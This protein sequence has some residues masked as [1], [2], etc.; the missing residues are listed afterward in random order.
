MFI[1]RDLFEEVRIEPVNETMN[2]RGIEADIES[3]SPR[4]SRDAAEV[5]KQ[6]SV[7]QGLQRRLQRERLTRACGPEQ[8]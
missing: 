4:W 6:P 8:Q 3:C 1:I 5:S 2:G 7:G